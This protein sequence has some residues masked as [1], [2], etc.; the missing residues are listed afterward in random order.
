MSN[1]LDTLNEEQKTAVTFNN[2]NLLVLAGAGTGKTRTIIARA[3][4]LI[5]NGVNPRRILILSFTRKSAKE[6]VERIKSLSSDN[7]DVRY[8][9][10]QTFHSWCMDLIQTNPKI[11]PY[12][13]HTC[14]DREDQE[15]AIRLICGRNFKKQ[16]EYQIDAKQ[17]L[18]VFSYTK[19]TLRSLSESISIKTYNNIKLE[20]APDELKR[21][22]NDSKVIYENII[23]R[24]IEFKNQRRYIDY[25]DI[26]SI[27]ASGL[28]N[29]EDARKYIVSNYDHI[30]V[31]EFQDTNPLQYDL[32]SSFYSDCSLFCVGDDAQSIYS[33]R[34]SDF[35]LIHQFTS[36]VPNSECLK[37]TL[38][39]RSTQEILD[40][41]NWLLSGSD[42]NYGKEL[43]ANRGNGIKPTVL[44]VDDKFDEAEDITS[45]II[46]CLKENGALYSDNLILSRTIFGLRAV[47]GKCIQK[48]IPYRMLGGVGFMQSKHIKD[49][50]SALRIVSNYWDELAWMRY[51]K[52]WPTIGDITS[53]KITDDMLNCKNLDDALFLLLEKH[54]QPEISDTLIAISNLQN[55]PAKAVKKAFKIMSKRLR[56]IYGKDEWD[57]RKNDFP[58][59]EDI[60]SYS[61]NIL[62]FITEYILDPKLGSISKFPGENLDHITLSTIH[63]A[64]GLEAKNCFIVDVSPRSYPTQ[65]AMQNGDD[66]IEEERRCLYVAMTRAKDN[67][68]LYSNLRE[69]HVEG[70]AEA[71]QR[72]YF[73]NNLPQ[74]L[75]NLEIIKRECIRFKDVY[76]GNPVREDLIS[77]FNFD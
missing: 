8:L 69:K 55:N 17:I 40:I 4:F 66:A 42:L 2:K 6:I 51:L 63:S 29:N 5:K 30:L 20:D 12:G 47:E 41:S 16:N 21:K 13:N 43:S 52:L 75:V 74:K 72:L 34:G 73:L 28:K 60:A 22:I 50:V 44:C 33:F 38:N 48:K 37:L 25:D 57:W 39:Y 1:Y 35:K 32:L 7:P 71:S 46:E 70:S 23:R 36:I 9:K 27:V 11:F 3:I 76:S 62:E 31:D 56:E 53:A 67:L 54:L 26:L 24:Y 10:G 65:R 59:L 58:I 61:P 68:Y 15:Q 45:K 77:D 14:M 19:N 49:L 64:K 18:E